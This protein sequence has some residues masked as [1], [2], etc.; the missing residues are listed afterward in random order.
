MNTD[1]NVAETTQRL[2]FWLGWQTVALCNSWNYLFVSCI[3][4]SK[5]STWKMD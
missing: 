4:M 5:C 2:K 3:W 1:N